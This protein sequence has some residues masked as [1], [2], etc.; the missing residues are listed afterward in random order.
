[1]D[2]LASNFLI[3]LWNLRANYFPAMC[4]TIQDYPERCAITVGKDDD[5]SLNHLSVGGDQTGY[6]N[7]PDAL[8]MDEGLFYIARELQNQVFLVLPAVPSMFLTLGIIALAAHGISNRPYV[9]FASSAKQYDRNRHLD[10]IRIVIFGMLGLSTIFSFAIAV[11]ASQMYSALQFTTGNNA[12]AGDQQQNPGSKASGT[13]FHV[14]RGTGAL[15]LQW[16]AVATTLLFFI[17]INL[18]ET[19]LSMVSF[20]VTQPDI[21]GTGAQMFDPSTMGGPLERA[22]LLRGAAPLSTA[23]PPSGVTPEAAPPQGRQPG[24]GNQPGMGG[25]MGGRGGMMGGRG[26]M[27]GGRG[28]M[29]GARGGMAGARGGMAGRGGMMAGRGGMM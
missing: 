12:S 11:G 10:I 4:A 20:A 15:A 13:F 18:T 28:G 1:L 2:I 27:M 17:A 23:P 3:N 19:K 5:S 21:A 24:M 7:L 26:G 25:M 6:Y 14:N 8:R 22:S 9:G 29:M 16:L